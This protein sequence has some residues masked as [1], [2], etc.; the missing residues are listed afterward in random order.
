MRTKQLSAAKYKFLNIVIL[1]FVAVN[2]LS[3]KQALGQID[4]Y[5]GLNKTG[6]RISAGVGATNLYTHF[7]QHPVKIA[8]IG[9]LYYDINPYISFGL[10]AQYGILQGIDNLHHLRY[11]SS[12]D[13]YFSGT[14]NIRV[15]LGAFDDFES[16]NAFSDAV[17]R[18]YIGVGG[19]AIRA[20]NVL[21]GNTGTT[22]TI[23]GL[24]ETRGRYLL[25][26]GNLGTYID[27]PGV[28]GLDRLEINPNLQFNYVNSLYLDGFRSTATSNLKGIYSIASVNLRYKF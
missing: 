17:K 15:A 11:Y 10:E 20:K 8:Y 28:L 2:V 6:I 18:I 22:S 4:Y 19:G 27:L 7:N 21:V 3:T 26:A 13:K 16:N 1:V 5:Y 14:A 25:I 23:Y 24:P 9:S 12:T